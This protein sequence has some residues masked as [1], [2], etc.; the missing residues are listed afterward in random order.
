MARVDLQHR[1]RTGLALNAHGGTLCASGMTHSTDTTADTPAHLTAHL[2]AQLCR[3]PGGVLGHR[4]PG[5]VPGLPPRAATA[6]ASIS[7]TTSPTRHPMPAPGGR[8]I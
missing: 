1:A 3:S 7:A 8:I 5:A 6:F 2:G 4:G